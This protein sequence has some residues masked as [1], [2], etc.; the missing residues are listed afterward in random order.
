MK[1]P[2]C[3]VPAMDEHGTQFTAGTRPWSSTTVWQTLIQ[4]RIFLEVP[5]LKVIRNWVLILISDKGNGKGK[6]HPRTGHEGPKGE[7]RYRSTLSLTSQLDWG[8]RS[9]PRTGRFT[10]GND[11]VPI[12]QEAGWAPGPVWT[13]ANNLAPHR[14]SI[15]GPSSP[16]LYRLSYTG[17]KYPINTSI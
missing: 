15:P 9:T 16:S 8:W 12:V 3:G 5:S 10:P 17:P 7:K 13:G 11:P 1:F 6:G 2:I 14:D 4:W